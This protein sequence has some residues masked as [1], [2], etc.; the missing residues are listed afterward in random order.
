MKKIAILI[1]GEIRTNS[2]G[3]GKNKSFCDSFK[4]YIMNDKILNE[5]EISI[6]FVT[7]KICLFKAKKFFGNYLKKI[8][9]LDTDNIK[10][11]LNL[12]E[13]I[14]KYNNYY[15]FRKNNNN[16]YPIVSHPR[17]SYVYMFYKLYCAYILMTEYEKEN[18]FKFDIII[19]IRPD[20]YI[21]NDICEQIKNIE[22]K[23]KYLIMCWDWGYI[24]NN[25]FNE[26]ICK[27]I[28]NYGK[29]NYGDIIHDKKILN[30]LGFNNYNEASKI[31][32]CWSESPEVQLIEYII[33]YI[34]A[35]N[36]KLIFF[37]T[38]NFCGVNDD[39]KNYVN[40]N[41]N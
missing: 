16:L 21:S 25:E 9:T 28:F 32:S 29:Y 27:L 39:R 33:E 11:P 31:W 4:K 35:N 23:N 2:L 12:E 6:F 5:Y 30:S 38:Y 14:D 41:N 26:Y 18:N 20:F 37:D 1:S 13:L 40:W 34:N 3:Y 15:N 10:E 22:N 7:D 36:I 24:A 17:P 8:L 19:K